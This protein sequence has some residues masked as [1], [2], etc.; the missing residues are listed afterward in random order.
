M[1]RQRFRLG[2]AGG[3]HGPGDVEP[4]MITSC[5]TVRGPDL[6]NW[7]GE[8]ILASLDTP[9]LW[10][11]ELVSFVTFSPRYVTDTLADIAKVGGTVG[12]GRVR[13]GHNPLQWERIDPSAMDYWGVGSVAVAG[14]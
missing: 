11:G 14:I 10:H 9:L 6:P 13:P 1:E 2:M 8:A 3:A 5:G 12:V 4:L 7:Q